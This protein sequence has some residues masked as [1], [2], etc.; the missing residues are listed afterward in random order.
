MIFI[1][2]GKQFKDFPLSSKAE[3]TNKFDFPS[4]SCSSITVPISFTVSLLL[5]QA[6]SPLVNITETLG[7]NVPFVF[8]LSNLIGIKTLDSTVVDS[9]SIS[10]A[11]VPDSNSCS[12]SLSMVEAYNAAPFA[13]TVIGSTFVMTFVVICSFNIS[14]IIKE[15]VGPPTKIKDDNRSPFILFLDN[16]FLQI[17]TE[18]CSIGF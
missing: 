6:L 13:T 5:D 3:T 12:A 9:Y 11:I 1:S 14:R 10:N 2:L 16:S 15:N 18:F 4:S 7:G 8:F 17:S